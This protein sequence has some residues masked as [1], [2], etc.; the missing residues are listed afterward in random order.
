MQPRDQRAFAQ[1]RAQRGNVRQANGMID[2]VIFALPPAAEGNHSL[3]Q[4]SPIHLSQ[5]AY[6]G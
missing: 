6:T 4:R 5:I 2:P 1:M 3:P